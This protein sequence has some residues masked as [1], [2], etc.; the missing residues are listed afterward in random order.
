MNYL[1][2]EDEIVEYKIQQRVKKLRFLNPKATQTEY[3]YIKSTA[4]I[5]HFLDFFK[6]LKKCLFI[7]N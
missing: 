7:I 4:F 2:C 6:I 3:S 5:G 1:E